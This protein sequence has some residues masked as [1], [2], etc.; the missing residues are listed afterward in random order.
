LPHLVSRTFPIPSP[1]TVCNREQT[2]IHRLTL[3]V[4]G[5][6]ILMYLWLG[7]VASPPYERVYHSLLVGE[8][9]RY[10]AA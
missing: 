4:I 6:F 9:H 10:H 1:E 3:L 5:V 2:A 8:H 7:H